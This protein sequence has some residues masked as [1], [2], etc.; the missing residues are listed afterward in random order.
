MPRLMAVCALVLSLFAAT[1]LRAAPAA[2]P[3]P[4][5]DAAWLA[6]HAATPGVVILDI[7][8]GAAWN[9]AH[10]PGAVMGDYAALPWRVALPSGA[11]GALPPPEQLA[12]TIGRLGIGDDDAVV[13]V[14]DDFGAAARV[15]W[16]FKVLGHDAVALLDG[17]SRAW[18]GPLAQGAGPARPQARFTAHYTPAPRAE[19]RDVSLAAALGTSRLVDA[20]PAGQFGAAHI[21]GAV[22][23]DQRGA[24][25]AD[26]HLRPAPELAA[27]FAPAGDRPAIAYCNTGHLGAADWF[28]LS[29]VLHRPARLYD[30]SMSEWAADPARPLV[31]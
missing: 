11:Q 4:L 16:S 29:E 7:R 27:M 20:R 25:A 5:V 30:G 9:A 17:G 3:G 14:S 31:R 23:I 22:S 8:P 1:P 13:V 12:A 28:V 15:Y 21:P 2:L 24:L 10:I 26:G 18:R 6:A 19:L